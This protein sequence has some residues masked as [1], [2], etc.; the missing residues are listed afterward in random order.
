MTNVAGWG[1]PVAGGARA[2]M[3]RAVPTA[4]QPTPRLTSLNTSLYYYT[5]GSGPCPEGTRIRWL[6]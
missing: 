5:D 4:A 2:A 1:A 3:C 6:G